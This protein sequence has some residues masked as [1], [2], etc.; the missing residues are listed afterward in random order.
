M[1]TVTHKHKFVRGEKK[2]EHDARVQLPIRLK[3]V[4]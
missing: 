4:S 2:G 1:V 3:P